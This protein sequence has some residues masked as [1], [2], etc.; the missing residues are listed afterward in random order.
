ML[1]F[2]NQP[3]HKRAHVSPTHKRNF[4]PEISFIDRGRGTELQLAVLYSVEDSRTR[5]RQMAGGGGSRARRSADILIWWP[6]APRIRKRTA[7][8]SGRCRSVLAQVPGSLACYVG[9]ALYSS[10]LVA[11]YHPLI[12]LGG[13]ESTQSGLPR[14]SFIVEEP[15]TQL[16]QH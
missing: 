9:D 5:L 3:K 11:E 6:T 15:Y 12:T 2:Q 10:S 13:S 16:H 14:H 7:S 1:G 4:E 8:S